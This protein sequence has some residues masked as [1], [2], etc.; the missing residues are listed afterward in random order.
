VR[1]QKEIKER[2]GSK[3]KYKERRTKKKREER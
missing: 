1:K 3:Q 2:K